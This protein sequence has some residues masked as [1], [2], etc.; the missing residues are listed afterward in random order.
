MG[1]IYSIPRT[2]TF[3]VIDNS[4]YNEGKADSN[5]DVYAGLVYLR[6]M[7]WCKAT[8]ERVERLCFLLASYNSA[9]IAEVNNVVEL[10]K[11]SQIGKTPAGLEFVRIMAFIDNIGTLYIEAMQSIRNH[12]AKDTLSVFT[13]VVK[14][15]MFAILAPNRFYVSI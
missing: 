4:F 12:S 11:T 5:S 10:I 6:N 1:C 8:S 15:L 13:D 3:A 14:M 9:K 2:E 7:T